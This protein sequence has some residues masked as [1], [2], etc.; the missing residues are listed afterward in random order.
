MKYKYHTVTAALLCCTLFCGIFAH[1]ASAQVVRAYRTPNETDLQWLLGDESAPPSPTDIVQV[2]FQTPSNT[3]LVPHCEPC[4]PTHVPEPSIPPAPKVL[5][6]NPMTGIRPDTEGVVSISPMVTDSATPVVQMATERLPPPSTIPTEKNDA[7]KVSVT[8]RLPLPTPSETNFFETPYSLTP[9]A[10][11]GFTCKST[12]T[13]H[14]KAPFGVPDMIGGSSWL[15]GY[16]IGA[17]IG[18]A[19]MDL[20]QPN[21]L[22]SRPNVVEH[23][24]ADANNRIWADYRHWNN[25]VSMG[26]SSGVIESRAVDQFSF[27]LEKRLLRGTSLELRVPLFAQFASKMR[28]NDMTATAVEL[29]NVSAFL[30][31]VLAKTARWTVAGGIGATLPT[32]ED[33]RAPGNAVRLNNKLYSL[34]SFLGV[35]W[36]PNH[37][38]FGHFVLQA[39]VPIEKNELIFGS[40]RCH[41]EGQ[42]MVHTAFQLGRWIYRNDCSKRACR[43]GSFVEVDYAIITKGTSQY[44]NVVYARAL[45][46]R[47]STLTA[48]VGIPMMFGN[49]TCTNSVILPI[50]GSPFSV[51]YNFSMVQQF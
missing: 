4:K 2:G 10:E 33:W 16:G 24:N 41:V 15:P 1:H 9:L 30:K 40:D 25:A 19:S 31:Q 34:T 46:A 44:G 22:L 18:T 27:G 5:S 11:E 48:A 8:E 50:S 3:A 43:L 14:K 37:D 49:L 51:G 13:S 42:Q 7:A 38:L 12:R 35:Q 23:F 36:H 29:G 17:N 45:N 47:K 39:D 32:A 26:D 21:M 28:A 6:N 20:V